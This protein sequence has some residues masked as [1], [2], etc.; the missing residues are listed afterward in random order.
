METCIV[1]ALEKDSVKAFAEKAAAT[2]WKERRER[3]NTIS[4]GVIAAIRTGNYKLH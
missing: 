3:I 1:N 2:T 4:P